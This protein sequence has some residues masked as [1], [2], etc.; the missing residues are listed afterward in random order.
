MEPVLVVL[1]SSSL[2]VLVAAAGILPFLGRETVPEWWLGWSNAGAAGVMLG[3]AYVL[4][5]RGIPGNALTLGGGAFLGIAFVWWS[6]RVSGTEELDLNVQ[7]QAS[8]DYGTNVLLV[9]ALHS[10]AEGLAIGAA[11]G[12]DLV[13]GVWMA[14][15]IALHNIP[16]AVLLAAVFRSQ[17]AGTARVALLTVVENAPI[18]P[19]AVSTFAVVSAAPAVGP[20]ALGFGAG[21]L[22]YLVTVDLLPESY[23]QAGATSIALIALVAMAIVAALQEL[24]P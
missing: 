5:A 2:A 15:A 9:G 24:V 8:Q 3:S 17:G 23:R 13:L 14:A 7:G 11:M 12:V 20:W 21:M 10:A 4:A 1:A 18:V 16:E 6:H 19:M 22:I